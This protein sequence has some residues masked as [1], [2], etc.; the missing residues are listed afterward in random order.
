MLFCSP[1]IAGR[2]MQTTMLSI[3][4]ALM[5][6]NQSRF[7]SVRQMLSHMVLKGV[8][9]LQDITGKNPRAGNATRVALPGT[10]GVT[11]SVVGYSSDYS[12]SREISQI[13][14]GLAS[15]SISSPI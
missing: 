4:S 8:W 5:G 1:A 3:P 9:L 11:L 7:L 10:C 14:V 15:V 13:H 6:V 2:P 12:S